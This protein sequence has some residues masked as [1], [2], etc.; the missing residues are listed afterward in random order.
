MKASKKQIWKQV[1]SAE[2]IVCRLIAAWCTF[3]AVNLFEEGNFYEVAFAQDTSLALVGFITLTVFGLYSLINFLVEK[4]ESDTWFL[5]GAATVCVIRWIW[6]YEKS[7]NAIKEDFLFLLA[8]VAVFSL[9]VIYFV[10]KNEALKD[11]LEPNNRVVWGVVI[12]VGAVSCGV[13]AIITCLRYMTFSA[14]N[15]DFGIFS[16]MFHNMKETGLPIT[17]CERDVAL[18]HFVVHLSPICYLLLP[19]YAI[20]PSP[21]TLQI[22][23]A[24]LLASGIIPV[25]LI[26]RHLKMSGKTTVIMSILYAFYLAWSV[27]SFYDFH[28]NCFLTPILLWMFYFFEK[29]KYP[30]MYLFAFLTLMVKEDAAIYVIIFALYVILGRKKYLHGGIL[31]LGSLAYFGIALAI[32]NGTS[33]YYADYYEQLGESANPGIAGAMEYRYGNLSYPQEDGLMGAVKTAIVNP[34]FLLTQLFG[35]WDKVVYALQMFLPLGFLPFCTKKASRWLLITPVLLNLLTNYQYQYQLSLQW[36]FQYHY[37]ITAF[38]IYV[39]ILNVSE[40]QAPT[41]QNLMSIAAVGCCCLYLFT[42][43]PKLTSYTDKWED[44]KEKFREMEAILDTIPEDASLC[45]SANLLAHVADR[46]EVYDLNYHQ[47]EGNVDY[48]IFDARYAIKEEQY[49]AY[50]AQGYTVKEEHKGKLLIL[51]KGGQD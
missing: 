12:A 41:K 46:E 11:K 13:I 47:N 40:L 26:C 5:L 19:F 9:F 25:M 20:F 3:A 17:T 14:P 8:V 21:L 29:E 39:S 15:F 51:E 10:H 49:N 27:G 24:L 16:Q 30:W 18:S 33:S 34:G 35:S 28:E 31:L 36:G 37:G 38:L 4:Y 50:L 45:V 6:T 48:V 44:G 42:V 2:R 1:F 7:A 32:L 23:Q 43:V 22:G